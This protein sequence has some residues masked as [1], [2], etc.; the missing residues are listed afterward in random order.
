MREAFAE[1]LRFVVAWS[2]L[3]VPVA[4]AAVAGASGFL[5]GRVTKKPEIHEIVVWK[6]DTHGRRSTTG[7]VRNLL[8]P[9]IEKG[10]KE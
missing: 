9:V 7:K 5:L 8:R 10:Q 4:A 3:L 1:V 2:W 6:K